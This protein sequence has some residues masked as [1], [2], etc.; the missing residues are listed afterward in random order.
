MDIQRIIQEHID[1]FDRA[2]PGA[3]YTVTV[4][5]SWKDIFHVTIRRNPDDIGRVFSVAPNITREDF[6][7]LLDMHFAIYAGEMEAQDKMA[8][9]REKRSRCIMC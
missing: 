2:H 4:T 6:K 5:P 9:Q 7:K 3:P 8:A 1:E